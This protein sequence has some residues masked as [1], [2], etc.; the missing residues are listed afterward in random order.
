MNGKY[1]AR[2]GRNVRWLYL[3]L[4]VES[5][6]EIAAARILLSALGVEGY[7]L[8]AAVSGAVG[9]LAFFH[10]SLEAAARRFVC[11]DSGN[12]APLFGLTLVLAG[13]TGLVGGV[14]SFAA[15]P[16]AAGVA[17]FV[18]GVIVVRLLRIPYETCIVADERMGFFLF[19][20]LAES[21][22]A[23]ATAALAGRLPFAPVAAYAGL[24]FASFVLTGG[25]VVAYCLG[26]HPLSRTRPRFGLGAVRAILGFFGWQALGSVAGLLKGSGLIVLL[27]AYAGAAGC[28]A[29]EAAGKFTVFIWGLIANYRM[30]YLPGVVKAWA[31]G[32]RTAFVSAT[33]RA[34]GWS[35]VGMTLVVVPV[36]VFASEICRVCFGTSVPDGSPMFLRMVALQFYFE[37]LAI[38]Y[39]TAILASGRIARYEI[40]LTALLGSSFFLAWL[41]LAAGLPAWTATGAV[42]LVNGFAFLFRLA[43]VRRVRMPGGIRAWSVRCAA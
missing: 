25:L 37:A 4:A 18:L 43:S 26:R 23:L 38:P 31:A 5:A 2:V 16:S 32:D 40:L 24:R 10:G 27:A 22:L 1:G 8:F 30:A 29:C 6:A 14:V 41:F 33:R 21:A 17:L 7:G 11:C 15:F 12:F 13:L 36:L 3:R 35:A 42:A 9:A 20:S 39:D 28:A 34:F 19:V